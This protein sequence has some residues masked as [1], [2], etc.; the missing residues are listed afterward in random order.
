MAS[1]RQHDVDKLRSQLDAWFRT[2]LDGTATLTAL[3]MPATGTVNDTF[4]CTVER[5][6]GTERYVVRAQPDG[7]SNLRDNDVMAQARVLQ[8]LGSVPGLRVPRVRWTDDEGA[9][10]GRPLYVM[11]AI[12]G[13]PA[14]DSPPYTL[15]GWMFDATPDERRHVYRQGVEAIAQVHAV[16]WAEVGL[17]HLDNRTGGRSALRAQFDAFREFVLWGAEGTRYEIIEAAY[18]WLVE[19]FPTDEGPTVLDWNDARLGNMLF[20]G[21]ELTGLLDWELVTVGPPE[22]DLV[23]FLWHDRFMSEALGTLIAGAPCPRLAG[24]PTTEEGAAWYRDASGYEPRDLEWFE[25]WCAYRMATYLMRHGKGMILQG[26][27]PPES[28]ADHVNMASCMLA[29]MLGIPEP[30]V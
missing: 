25:V 17:G 30:T 9:V 6:S 13:R 14:A 16:P 3:D 24:S 23:W 2:V 10:L 12:P 20:D 5:A 15:E 21:V 4:V 7:F 19:R 29:R 27:V 22:V 18:D 8:A 28:R 26:M 11:D 1:V